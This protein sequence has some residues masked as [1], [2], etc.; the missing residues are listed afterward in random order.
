MTLNFW[1]MFLLIEAQSL[2]WLRKGWTEKIVR[3]FLK[4][5]IIQQVNG[6]LSL[7]KKLTP[8]Y[9]VGCKR[10][11]LINDYLPIFANKTNAHLVTETIDEFTETGIKTKDEKE[12]SVDLVVLATG[13]KVEESICGFEIIGKDGMYL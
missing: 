10:I 3:W 6:D 5:S 8:T 2:L 7:A 9:E 1:A 13:F 4:K 11:L 12:I